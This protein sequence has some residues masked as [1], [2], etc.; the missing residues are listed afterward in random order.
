ML[1]GPL[2]K[3]HVILKENGQR[4]SQEDLRIGA[5]IEIYKKKFKIIDCDAFTRVISNL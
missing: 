1:Q 4:F 2:V 5:I 3:K